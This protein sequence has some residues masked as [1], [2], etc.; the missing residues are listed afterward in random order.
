MTAGRGAPVSV[1]IAAH[2]GQHVIER[3]V[4]SVLAQTYRNPELLVVDDG[5]TD[6][7]VS[8]L[9]KY[10]DRM[11]VIEQENLG[12]LA[13]R[14][15]GAREAGG[16]YIAFLDQDD[17]WVPEKLDMQVKVLD[18]N[19]RIG[20]VFGKLEAVDEQG[21]SKGF[22]TN[23]REYCR[24]PSLDDMI[25]IFPLY[26]SSAL[27]RKDLFDRIGG[28]DTRFGLSGAYGDQ[29]F[30]IRLRELVPFK[31]ADATVGYYTWDEYRPGRIE[32]FVTNL[33]IFA[34]KYFN[35][36][37]LLN[38]K[39]RP[40]RERFVQKCFDH[41]AYL[42]RTLLRRNK[43]VVTLEQ[44]LLANMCQKQFRS[45]FGDSCFRMAG[46]GPLNLDDFASNTAMHTLLFLYLSRRDL[47]VRFPEV[48]RGDTGRLYGWAFGVAS[49]IHL[50]IDNVTL[51]PFRAFFEQQQKH[52]AVAPS[53]TADH[54]A[55]Y[56]AGKGI[57]IGE[58]VCGLALPRV[59]RVINLD[60]STR[61][62][63]VAARNSLDFIVATHVIEGASNLLRSFDEWYRCL[64]PGGYLLLQVADSR[65]DNDKAKPLTTIRHVFEDWV[66]SVEARNGKR[67]LSTHEHVWTDIGFRELLNYVTEYHVPFKIIDFSDANPQT[68][69][70]LCLL[71]KPD[72]GA[73]KRR[74]GMFI[75][76]S[77]FVERLDRIS[78][79]KRVIREKDELVSRLDYEVRCTLLQLGEIQRSF[80]YKVIRFCSS[81]IDR[82]FPDGTTRGQ[83]RKTVVLSLRVMTEEGFRSFL[84]KAL[85]SIR[86][87]K[88]LVS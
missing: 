8:I 66:Q 1:V 34:E 31:F 54:L 25:L 35:H 10:R 32:T 23:P 17:Y 33:G 83:M 6:M 14:N 62:T 26:P 51:Y 2:N 78:E 38:S 59:Q 68:K 15:L 9:N 60:A 19:P 43:N 16:R 67:D 49:G 41:W 3:A 73:S 42:M 29:D 88:L 37:Y 75:R 65:F 44:L 55:S 85:A 74:R 40:L 84:A 50:D 58:P 12:A 46:I 79:L 76:E 7:T 27:L 30:H 22:M 61:L 57:Q 64:K 69:C 28:F 56:I 72:V 81:G 63:E 5:S 86:R 48:L 36:P 20:L 87:G 80:G 13:A 70:F 45:I 47:Q 71:E 18:K 21:R 77:D 52:V 53:V 82:A 24:S 11:N 39:N 4:R